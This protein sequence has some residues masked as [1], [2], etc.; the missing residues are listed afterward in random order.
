M[1]HIGNSAVP[2]YQSATGTSH[3]EFS[4]VRKQC[5]K[6]FTN[7][8]DT[9]VAAQLMPENSDVPVIGKAFGFW[10]NGLLTSTAAIGP[11]AYTLP[12]A[13]MMVSAYPSMGPDD[14]FIITIL[15]LNAAQ[16]VTLVASAGHSISGSAVCAAMSATVFEIERTASSTFVCFRSYSYTIAA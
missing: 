15:N 12:T 14:T 8:I 4:T 13:A 3:Q 16:T 2:V 7:W 10:P 5:H 11:V 6:G 9:Q 1:A